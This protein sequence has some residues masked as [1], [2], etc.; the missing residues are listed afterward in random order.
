VKTLIGLA[1]VVLVVTSSNA[2]ANSI[3]PS[4]IYSGQL[5]IGASGGVYPGSGINNQQVL[6]AAGPGTVSGSQTAPLYTAGSSCCGGANTSDASDA[7]ASITIST[8]PV[9][10]ISISAT[11]GT[12]PNNGAGAYVVASGG[13]NGFAPGPTLSYS[14]E[15]VGAPGQVSVGVNASGGVS[16]TTTAPGNYENNLFVSFSVGRIFTDSAGYG[17]GVTKQTFSDTNTYTMNANQ[18]YTV[19]LAT[20]LA[21]A[22]SGNLG[23]GTETVSAFV[24]PQFFAP[25]GYTVDFSPGIGISSTATPL[26]AALPLFTTGL[27]ALGLLGWRRKRKA[28]AIA[29]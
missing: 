5:E 14:L 27:G 26:P 28:S 17:G 21:T 2:M 18:I 25:L 7:S 3:L 8:G 24:D 12:I 6:Q 10:S 11:V 4:A 22:I 9:P 20:Y 19:T 13:S 15:I 29:A 1:G 23:G 16:F